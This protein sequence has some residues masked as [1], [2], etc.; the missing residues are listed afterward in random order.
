MKRKIR[1]RL[2]S[3]SEGRN[4]ISTLK[5]KAHSLNICLSIVKRLCFLS[6]IIFINEMK[7][8][9]RNTNTEKN[10]YECYHKSKISILFFFL[11]KKVHFFI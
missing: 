11:E 8:F 2:S 7:S 5:L 4:Y 10:M 1:G 9:E 6:L 3:G